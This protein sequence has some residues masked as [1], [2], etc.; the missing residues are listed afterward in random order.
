M[1]KKD[2]AQTS[3]FPEQLFEYHVL[4]SPTDEV[5]EH[6]DM[7]KARLNDIIDIGA[8]NIKSIAHISLFK[9][10]AYQSVNVKEVFTKGAALSEIMPFLIKIEGC[11]VFSAGDS[12]S[13]VLEIINPQPIDYL[14]ALLNPAKKRKPKKPVKQT[15]ILDKPVKKPATIHPHITIARNIAAE[16]LA[17]VTDLSAFD[18]KAEFLCDRITILKRPAGTTRHFSPGGYIKLGK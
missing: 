3:L 13:L 9:Y 17:L 5:I 10:E 1:P 8:F 2:P 18:Y 7:L 11:K 14:A 6:V 4:I 12:R 16:E 15:S